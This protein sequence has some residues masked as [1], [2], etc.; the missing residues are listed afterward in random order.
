[1]PGSMR[2]FNVKAAGLNPGRGGW[3]LESSG[4]CVL[5]IR[6]RAGINILVMNIRVLDVA[7]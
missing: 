1:M 5:W 4:R 7:L 2:A 3:K 6:R